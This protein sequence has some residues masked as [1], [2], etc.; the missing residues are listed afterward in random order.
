MARKPEIGNVQLYPNRSLLKHDK[1]GTSSS[2]SVRCKENASDAIVALV[3]V[4]KQNVCCSNVANG[5]T[6]GNTSAQA[7]QSALGMN[8]AACSRVPAH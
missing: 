5:C 8:A 4:G 2:F 7:E 6:M 3:I 1:T